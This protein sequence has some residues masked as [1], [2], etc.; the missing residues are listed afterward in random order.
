MIKKVSGFSY[1]RLVLAAFLG[2]AL[3][4]LVLFGLFGGLL[5]GFLLFM[6]TPLV[7]IAVL[8]VE[9][10]K[11]GPA[12]GVVDEAVK[13]DKVLTEAEEIVKAAPRPVETGVKDR[14][15]VFS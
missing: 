14:E 4:L 1:S 7:A 3:S 2:F 13:D 11:G 5:L 10:L 9:V 12:E 6:L 15:K 8:I